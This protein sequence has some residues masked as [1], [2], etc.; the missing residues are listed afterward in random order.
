MNNTLEINGIKAVI[1]F[2][3]DMGMFRG[4]FIGLNGGADF[5]ASDVVGLKHEGAISLRVFMQAC[6]EDGVEPYRH[7]SGKFVARVPAELHALA[8]EAAKARG[9]SLNTLVEQA[10]RHEV[11]SP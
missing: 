6:E 2:D 8:S 11:E 7:Y 4:E 1:A 9:V 3:P 5:Y 10:L